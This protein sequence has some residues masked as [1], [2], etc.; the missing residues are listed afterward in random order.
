V[1]EFIFSHPPK[2][3]LFMVLDDLKSDIKL[4]KLYDFAVIK[5]NEWLRLVYRRK[6]EEKFMGDERLGP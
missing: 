3:K 4:K 1:E 6:L 2:Q 5:R